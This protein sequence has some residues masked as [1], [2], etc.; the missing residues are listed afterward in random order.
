MAVKPWKGVVDHSVPTGYKPSKRDG[1]GPDASLTLEY[2]HGYRCHDARN[3]LRY[4]ATGQI[5]YHAAG[6]GIVLD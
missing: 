5:V 1:E 6:T 2:I 4:T 3:N